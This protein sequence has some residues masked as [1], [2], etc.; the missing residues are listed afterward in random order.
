MLIQC[1]ILQNYVPANLNRDDSGSPKSARFG[2]HLRGRISS[3]CLKRSMRRSS[4]FEA[5][6]RE[7]GM[8]ADRTNRLPRLINDELEQLGVDKTVRLN[9]INRL[10][11]LG[12]GSKLG[13]GSVYYDPEKG[14]PMYKDPKS[15]GGSATSDD[16][17]G[18]PKTKDDEL[19]TKVLVYL[20]PLE[21]KIVAEKLWAL[22][23]E[24]GDK[25]FAK[26]SIKDIEKA[27]KHD[28]PRSVDIAMFGRMTTSAAFEDV[29]AAVQLAHAI[30]TNRLMREFDYFTAVDDLSGETGAGMIGDLEMNSSTY[31]KYINICWDDLVKNL[32]D[33]T[34]IA[35]QAVTALL[36][37][38]ALAQPSGKQNSTAAQ[39]LPDFMLVEISQKNIPV[40]YANAFLKPV[41]ETYNQSLMHNS[42]EAFKK[43]AQQM[44]KA[45]A[46][47]GSQAFFTT[48][49]GM[50]FDVA[51]DTQSLPELQTW[52]KK[53]IQGAING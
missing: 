5:A 23:Q 51:T 46:L 31:Y 14:W 35:L 29:E 22:Y 8:L 39:N 28:T 47:N 37:A 49:E 45:Y 40:S 50:D 27:L 11:E 21:A 16:D 4:I 32:G 20:T 19:K 6:F 3:Q 25:E 48:E 18:E 44:R 42:I 41:R 38:A 12:G 17:G 43:Y 33:E 36:E 26:K 9:I 34:D 7:A 15:G 52:V 10:P 24:D 30:S 2:G 53:E 1:H 13:E